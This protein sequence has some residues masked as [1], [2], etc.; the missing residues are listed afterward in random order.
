M[1]GDIMDRAFK[2]FSSF[3]CLIMTLC[4]LLSGCTT[5]PSW[6]QVV[7]K[8]DIIF[9]SIVW[10][11]YELNF[12]QADGSNHQI[13]NLNQSF[14]KPIWSSDGMIIYGLSSPKW[15][16]SLEEIGFPAYWD[17]KQHIFK[18]CDKNLPAYGQIEE[19][20][21]TDDK[22][23]VLLYN[24]YEIVIFDM[25][26]CQVDKLL[27]D[28]NNP[29][30]VYYASGF[31]YLPQ[32][33]ELLYGRYTVA[34]K[35]RKFSLRK[36][37]LMTGEEKELA[38]GIN[39]AWSPDGRQ[40]AYLGVD[41]LYLMQ[42]DGQQS[43]KI[44]NEQFFDPYSIGGPSLD[45]PQPYWSPDGEWLVYHQCN[46]EYCDLKMATINKIHVLDGMEVNIYTGGKYP[47]WAP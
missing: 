24:A 6:K 17:I 45:S 42:T 20:I 34:E 44:I 35:D 30:G 28:Y 47:S 26:T 7:P 3:I 5:S 32:T 10:N 39:P 2:L 21:H 27:V 40:I 13:L 11:P 46:D 31:S 22:N 38:E 1:K 16:G 9:Q 37:S 41:G 12:I 15:Q 4:L 14:I 18:R 29:S 36:L 8:S 25:N 23:I 33:Q 43:R 19:F